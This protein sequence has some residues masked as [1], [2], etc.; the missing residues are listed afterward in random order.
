MADN[1]I[2]KVTKVRSHPLS[3]ICNPT[4]NGSSKLESYLH[5]NT[6]RGGTIQ[7]FTQKKLGMACGTCFTL[8]DQS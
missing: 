1:I 6:K 2:F 4:A 3:T 7:Y 5:E 8:A